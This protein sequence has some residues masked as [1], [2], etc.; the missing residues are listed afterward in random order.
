VEEDRQRF[1]AALTQALG[2]ASAAEPVTPVTQRF[3]DGPLSLLD[4]SGEL[5]LRDASSLD[6]LFRTPHLIGLGTIPLASGGVVRRDMWEDY[7]DQV[8][9]A[10][11]LGTPVVPIDG[12]TRPDYSSQTVDV[13]LTTNKP[14]GV[15]A[16]GDELAVIVKNRGAKTLHVELVGT[17][18][19]GETVVLVPA[20]AK[21]EPGKELRFPETGGITV[22]PGVGNERI[23]LFASES[24]FAA[25]RPL[26]GRGVL[27]RFVHDCY[28]T[29]TGAGGVKLS[30]DPATI[31][32]KTLVIETR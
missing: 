20:G 23:V 5:G 22:Q 24:E 3:L 27:D 7:F 21:I 12:L 18:T 13:E 17:G 30:F 25:G 6:R 31:V 4:I 29:S 15:F 28:Q 14:N 32:K 16:P 11:G 8:V 1:A 2:H 9:R 26:K 10:L 19:R